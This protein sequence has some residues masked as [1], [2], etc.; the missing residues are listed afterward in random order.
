M[1]TAWMVRDQDQDALVIN[2]AGRQR[3]LVQQI[4]SQAL[5]IQAGQNQDEH[6][7][8]LRDATT[9]FDQTLTALIAGGETQYLPGQTVSVPATGSDTIRAELREL[10]QRWTMFQD[11][12]RVIET[13]S[14]GIA[15]FD[16]AIQ[17]LQ[18]LSPQ[19]VQ[20]AD[21]IV[22]LIEAES[23]G[24]LA[25]LGWIQAGFF[26]CAVGLL[27]IGVVMIRRAIMTPL[28]T[29]KNAA[30]Q[31]G[32]GDLNSPVQIA[33][34]P[35]F[36]ELAISVDTMRT[37]LKT[38]TD[39]LEA[40]IHQRTRELTALYDVIREIS[41]HL[42]IA[43]VLDSVTGK[44]RD[45]LASDVAF[46]CLLDGTGESLTLKA[47]NGPQDAVCGSCVLAKHSVAAQVL[48]RE[49][50]MICD[51]GGCQTV[52]PDY[53]ASHLAAPLRVGERVI[54]ALCVGSTRAATY[55]HEQVRLLTELANSTA[56]AL[57]NARLY[58]QAER[59]A[60]LEERQRIA[61][62]MHD[63][64]A[65]TLSYVRL[66]TGRLADLIARDSNEQAA[67]ELAL[68]SD[69][70]DRA[71]H[72]VRQS[73]ASLRIVPVLGRTLQEHLADVVADFA[74]SAPEIAVEVVSANDQGVVLD[75]DAMAQVLRVVLEALQNARRHASATRVTI[76]LER[77]GSAYR[78]MI[79]DNGCGFD[80]SAVNGKGHFGLSIMQ[81]RA[82]RIGGDLMIDSAPGQGTHVILTWPVQQAVPA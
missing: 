26:L 65:Q 31:I 42:D 5:Q 82:A 12:L 19:L 3:M 21:E 75:S 6:R 81:A 79:H 54:G 80:P 40:R 39:G 63:G 41:S 8:I 73:I 62:D 14:P 10:Q 50:A 36:T 11:D 35:E 56:I 52:A 30:Q 33:G 22:R 27:V 45:L 32:Q 34:P 47:Y 37:Q 58:E 64:L 44:A 48:G 25:H 53:R 69:A 46:L 43:H 74:Q 70:V 71:G 7:Q 15:S 72:E 24:K 67:Q 77:Q 4:T 59:V 2:L 78:V 49:E 66:K 17:S 57:E 13:A 76:R 9:V 60:A 51:V 23:E 61:A 29:L 1:A 16:A 38:L 68:I 55:S 18:A 28:Q 20:Q